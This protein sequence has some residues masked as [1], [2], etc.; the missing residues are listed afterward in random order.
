MGGSLDLFLSRREIF[1]WPRLGG[2]REDDLF[3][4]LGWRLEVVAYFCV[5]VEFGGKFFC[6]LICG[7]LGCRLVDW[8]R[9]LYRRVS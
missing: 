1:I 9:R 3:V 2:A 4:V 6:H 5:M 8:R 7:C